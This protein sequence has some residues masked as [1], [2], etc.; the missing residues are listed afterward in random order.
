MHLQSTRANSAKE[1]IIFFAH[2][3]FYK[4]HKI[5][6]LADQTCTVIIM[7]ICFIEGYQMA[8]VVF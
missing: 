4:Y 1:Q 2:V 6:M 7:Y 5:N 3:H 8:L